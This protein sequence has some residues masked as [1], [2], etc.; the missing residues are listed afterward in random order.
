MT[1]TIQIDKNIPIPDEP[2]LHGNTRYPWL[3]MNIGD[4]FFQEP[5]GSEDQTACRTRMVV[6]RCGRRKLHGEDYVIARVTENGIDGVR[7]WKTK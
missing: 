2:K 4:S 6:A 1:M 7:I 3:E 5:Q